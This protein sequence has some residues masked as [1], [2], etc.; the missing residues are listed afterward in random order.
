MKIKFIDALLNQP[1]NKHFLITDDK[2]LSYEDFLQLVSKTISFLQK[3]NN[4]TE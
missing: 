3:S 1:P 4:G 2:T